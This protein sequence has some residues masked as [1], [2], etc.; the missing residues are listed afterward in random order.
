MFNS[1]LYRGRDSNGRFISEKV[2]AA[3]L[4]TLEESLKR[5][6]V[7]KAQ[8]GT[9]LAVDSVDNVY[10]RR[11]LAKESMG[12]PKAHNKASD[13]KGLAQITPTVLSDYKK[14]TGD[15]KA[16]PMNERDAIKIHKWYMTDLFNSSFINKPDQTNDIRTAKALAAYNWGRGNLFDHLTKQKAAGKDIYKSKDWMNELP[17]ETRDYVNKILYN[18]DATFD[19]DAKKVIEPSSFA[20]YYP[21]AKGGAIKDPMGQ[22]A[23]PG[24]VTEIPSSDIT[25]KGVPY[26]V[27]GKSDNG[28]TAVMQPGQDYK[29]PGAKS[30]TEY[31]MMR[32]GGSF[33]FGTMF[34][35]RRMPNTFSIHTGGSNWAT[36]TPKKFSFNSKANLGNRNTQT[37]FNK[38]RTFENGGN[39]K[40][41]FTFAQK[42]SKLGVNQDNYVLQ[43]DGT[44]SDIRNR[45]LSNHKLVHVIP[46]NKIISPL[47]KE[48]GNAY[49]QNRLASSYDPETE[50]YNMAGM[51]PAITVTPNNKGTREQNIRDA[52]SSVVEHGLNLMSEPQKRMVQG[53]TGKYQTPS[54]AMNVTNP[55]GAFLTDAIL[56]PVNIMGAGAASKLIKMGV[57]GGAKNV[58]KVLPKVDVNTLKVGHTKPGLSIHQRPKLLKQEDFYKNKE[59]DNLIKQDQEY[60]NLADDLDGRGADGLLNALRGKTEDLTSKQPPRFEKW[61]G[62]KSQLKKMDDAGLNFEIDPGE[63]HAYQKYNDVVAKSMTPWSWELSNP[64]FG[65]KNSPFKIRKKL[66]LNKNGGKMINNMTLGSQPNRRD[67]LKKGV[68]AT[69]YPLPFKKG[70]KMKFQSGGKPLNVLPI[71]A[72]TKN[73]LGNY[74]NSAFF[75]KR[76]PL[77]DPDL[78]DISSDVSNEM[79][80]RDYELNK[81]LRPNFSDATPKGVNQKVFD[82]MIGYPK[83]EQGGQIVWGGSPTQRAKFGYGGTIMNKHLGDN[84]PP[85]SYQ[86]GGKPLP[87]IPNFPELGP[88]GRV[89]IQTDKKF[90]TTNDANKFFIEQALSKSDQAT[91]DNYRRLEDINDG[92]LSMLASKFHFMR[93]KPKLSPGTKSSGLFS[94]QGSYIR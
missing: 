33:R 85:K 1:T 8:K 18:T 84:F 61:A 49:R 51:L 87:P 7:P 10:M 28:L 92:G 21:L 12:D 47:D 66:P 25:M 73:E 26:P 75:G 39:I 44:P 83:K 43:G 31:P 27:L 74:S 78:R 64:A 30:V 37:L 88:D 63:V 76:T 70:G 48:Y 23:H 35:T 38:L 77:N 54:Q 16:D 89:V 69:L 68:D 6:M 11:Q 5:A 32:S 2:K 90:K 57:K 3:P 81:K 22:W 45:L 67:L 53:I 62:T 20:K 72:E 4:M 52:G 36:Q 42:G 58:G 79:L 41:A 56:D 14:A 94:G 71:R 29:F 80:I 19:K 50:T 17:L 82:A 34:S 59:L 24:K 46:N 13:A 86:T 15:S 93:P 65:G 55:M 60:M 91:Q 40:S 9:K